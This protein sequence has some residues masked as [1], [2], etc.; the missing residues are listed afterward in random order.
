MKNH[1]VEYEKTRE[2]LP[3]IGMEA[4]NQTFPPLERAGVYA[5]PVLP[6]KGRE[7]NGRSFAELAP[8]TGR[9]G[10]RPLSTNPIV[11]RRRDR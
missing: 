3:L 2:A 11:T 8:M 1:S 5:Y 9:G 10:G 7:H 4:L 6:L